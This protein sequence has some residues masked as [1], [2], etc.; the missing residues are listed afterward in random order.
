MNIGT[1]SLLFGVHQFL[2]HPL[3]V[4]WAW[5]KLYGFP[6]DLHLWVAFVIHDWGYWGCRELDGPEGQKHSEWA[7][8]KMWKWF[9]RCYPGYEYGTTDGPVYDLKWHDFCLYHSRIRA[10]QDGRP[11]SRLCVADKLSVTLYPEWLYLLLARSSGEIYE[12]M[13]SARS[14]VYQHTNLQLDEQRF[15]YRQAN[16]RISERRLW[17]RLASIWLQDWVAEHK[18][19]A[20]D[21]WTKLE[22]QK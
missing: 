21:A 18:D 20:E 19:G 11:F 17:L 10:K 14:G 15:W 1:K 9:D 16:L 2:L 7:A 6:R 4:A 5:Y 8:W 13:E 22:S 12:Y 3:F